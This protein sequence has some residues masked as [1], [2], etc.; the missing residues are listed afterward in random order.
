MY[1]L[2]LHTDSLLL[3]FDVR[4]VKYTK[5]KIIKKL[6][7]VVFSAKEE[8]TAEETP[9][10][11]EPKAEE[12]V[13]EV[14]TEPSPPPEPEVDASHPDVIAMVDAAV[15]EAE[16]LTMTLPP[17]VIVEVMEVA[18]AEVEKDMRSEHPS[19]PL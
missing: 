1:Q 19:G 9:A 12:P 3:M 5:E 10:E 7:F 14:E 11:T 18:I 8:E 2:S 16:K 6:C 4:A 13:A 17:E 15:A